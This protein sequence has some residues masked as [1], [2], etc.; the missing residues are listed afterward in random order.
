MRLMLL[1]V[2]LL[3][4][5]LLQ[6]AHADGPE[7]TL[8][9][10]IP[11]PGV[12][13]RIDHLALDPGN[14]RLFVAALGNN[15][16]EVI[17]L[18]K[19]ERVKSIGG[20]KE[21]QGVVFV[22]DAKAV[23]VASGGDGVVREYDAMTLEAKGSVKVGDDADNIR[24]SADGRA[25]VVGY[26]SGALAVLDAATLGKTA[27]VK[28]PGHPESFQL[29][30]GGH[31][32]FINIPGGLVGGGGAVAVVDLTAQ[33][34]ANTWQLKEAGRNFPMALDAAR[35][36]LYIG[37]RRPARL[38]VMDT[39]NGKVIASPECI[40]D[41]DEVFL[42]DTTGRVL[43]VGGSGAID[44]F[45]AKDDHVAKVASVKTPGGARTGLLISGQ[46][47]LFVAVPE[48]GKQGAEIREYQLPD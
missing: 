22:P 26:G 46:R 31:L 8:K 41:A 38:L 43:V 25:V 23:F 30:P 11:L 34:V 20:L 18:A 29:D 21:P 48:S 6:T 4:G 2:M 33:R 47:A 1:L 24:L 35:K 27:E 12:S 10:A 44:V 17:D 39:D 14:Q 15:S 37:C 19:G 13:G 42:D 7:P 32:A 28:L 36:R 16:L 40:G 3:T 45:E 5:G 9:R